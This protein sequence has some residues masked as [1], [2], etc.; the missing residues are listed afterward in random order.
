MT[1]NYSPSLSQP[2]SSKP[3]NVAAFA[4]DLPAWAVLMA[5]LMLATI[6]RLM[7]FN[8]IFGSD[9]LV[10]LGRAVQISEGSWSSANYIGSLRYGFNIPAGFFTYLF[11]VNLFAANLWSLLCSLGEIA[12]IYWFALNVWDRRAALYSSLILV[13]M[14]LHI[15]VSSRIH[16]DPIASFFL[17]LSFFLF[18]VAE[19][20]RR[21]LLYFVTGLAM[22]LVFWTKEVLL[23][24]LFVF[25]LY[26]LLA[27]R[28]DLRWLYIV[29][30]GLTMLFAHFLLMF[31]IAGDPLHLFKITTIQI[32][33]KLIHSN[34]EDQVWYYFWY[35]FVDIKHTWLAPFLAAITIIAVIRRR[36]LSVN[37]DT[38]I[39]Y[40]V[41]WLISLIA[42]LSFTLISWEPLRFIPKQSNYMTLFLAPI[43]LL[44]G[45]LVARFPRRI[46]FMVLAVIMVGGLALGAL[47]Q[48]AYQVFTSNSKAAIAFAKAHP[49]SWIAGST[50]NGNIA[51]V[52]SILDKDPALADRFGYLKQGAFPE[53][54]K[55]STVDRMAEGYAVLDWETMEW[56]SD[57]MKLDKPPPCWQEITRLVPTG[58]GFSQTLVKGMLAIIET[59]PDSVGRRLAPPLQRLSQPQPAIVY[60][61][62]GT[63][64]WC[65]RWK[66]PS[67]H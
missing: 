31:V 65:E 60:R 63:D 11:G 12:T 67:T 15:A 10:Y 36:F 43:A 57:A 38:G 62:N 1:Q 17:T 55:V 4:W 13:C 8:G 34:S 35:L 51:L 32:D 24:A 47:E 19:Q 58:F 9:D 41:F 66:D 39:A 26:P 23:I 28:F 22:G 61:V 50:N 5:V 18:F 49:E 27:R 7:F 48:Q 53:R 21:P 54:I 20:Q 52:Y 3:R 40:V 46:G 29:G 44:A 56:G 6:M 37:I 42:V 16:A 59:F 2:F 64:F 14:P 25:A 33:R 45:Y 30:G